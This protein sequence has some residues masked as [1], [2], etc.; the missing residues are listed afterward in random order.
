MKTKKALETKYLF[1]C[2]F[3]KKNFL[4]VFHKMNEIILEI[5]LKYKTEL[6]NIFNNGEIEDKNGLILGAN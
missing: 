2:F 1:Q 5:S 3:T 4:N 6:T